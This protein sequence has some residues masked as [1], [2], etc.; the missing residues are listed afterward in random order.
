MERREFLRALATAGIVIGT[1]TAGMAGLYDWAERDHH[2]RTPR[3]VRR[4]GRTLV[5]RRKPASDA[6]NVLLLGL[7][8]CNDW[9]GFLNNHPGTRTP[10]LD[11]LAAQSLVFEHAYTAAPL[12]LPSRTAML[13]GRQPYETGIYDHSPSSFDR[14]ARLQ[15]VTASLV[16]DFWG[17]GYDVIGAGKVFHE[18]TSAR[19]M[20]YRPTN[21][22]RSG[23][24]RA[25]APAG[26]YDPNWRSP[27]DGSRIGR[28][29]NFKVPKID[30]G[31]SGRVPDT[32]P[33]GRTS[34]WVRARLRKPSRG[35]LFLA[36]G[37][38]LPHEPWRLP[39]KYLDMH[40]LDQVVVPPFRPHDLDDLSTYAKTKMVDPFGAFELLRASGIWDEA[41]Q[42]YQAAITFVDDRIGEV[43]DQ[44]A[45]SRLADNTIIGL[46]SDHGY[47]LG[48]KLTI[49]KFTL[50]ERATRIPLVLHVPGR[51]DHAA[52]FE[53]PVSLMQLGP[54][55]CELCDVTPHTPYSSPSALPMLAKPARADAH[56][57]IMTWYEGNHAVRRGPWRY[58]RY[59]TGDTELYDHRTDPNEYDNLAGRRD[60]ASVKAELDRFL[61]RI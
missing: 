9:L 48:E 52:R 36:F 28:G 60:L 26:S 39:Q 21:F 2:R 10:N 11:A 61:P 31:P 17:A 42:A 15:R 8:D 41:V 51:L 53:P 23:D 58:I 43:L 44:L 38:V 3:Q 7:D 29:E 35:P 24:A 59:V 5:R 12:C 56:P 6:P 19:W 14:Y 1:G 40:P 46:W 25:T 50:W 55:L 49:E 16:D 37:C 27:Y 47:H 54:T 13:F 32:E 34:D 45:H 20:S 33:D 22:Y 57:P 30:F 4:Y 18:E